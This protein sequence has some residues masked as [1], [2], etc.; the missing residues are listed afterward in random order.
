MPGYYGPVNPGNS[1][2]CYSSVQDAWE[3]N[4]QSYNAL[5]GY[6]VNSVTTSGNTM[7]MQVKYP[8]NVVLP[9]NVTPS[10]AAIQCPFSASSYFTYPSYTFS[11]APVS[12]SALTA[13]DKTAISAGFVN[14]QDT[15][16]DLLSS[17]YA[18]GL[19]LLAIISAVAVVATV[20]SRFKRS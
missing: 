13:T 9:V 3:A 5:A 17:V 6:H 16:S 12:A 4:I 18:P 10:L 8:S 1:G 7:T 19:Y 14:L 15:T 11:S 2:N 20:I